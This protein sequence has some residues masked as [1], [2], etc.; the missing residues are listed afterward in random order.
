MT[1]YRF[2]SRLAYART[3]PSR[4]YFDQAV[5][6]AEN[7]NI[8]ARSWQLAGRADQVREPGQ[9]FTTTIAEEPLLILVSGFWF[10]GLTVWSNRSPL[11]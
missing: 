5:F 7:R 4:F 11:R 9:F 8:F 2:D 3:I 1:D 6:D 10:P